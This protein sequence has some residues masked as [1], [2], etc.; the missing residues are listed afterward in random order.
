VYWTNADGD[1]GAVLAVPVSGDGTGNA[2]AS[3][4]SDPEGIAVDGANV[5]FT[6]Y[7]TGNGDGTVASVGIDGGEVITLATGQNGP[8]EIAVDDTSVYWITADG[9][10]MKLTPK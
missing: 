5:Y 8:N 10:V 7:G 6:T 4:I 2:L 9:N 1:A 3:G